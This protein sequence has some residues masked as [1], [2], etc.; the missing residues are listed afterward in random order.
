MGKM[1]HAQATRRRRPATIVAEPAMF[2]RSGTAQSS[3]L[4]CRKEILEI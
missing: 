2:W 1:Q 4:G 3:K